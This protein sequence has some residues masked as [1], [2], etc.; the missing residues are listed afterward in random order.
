M[1]TEKE[2]DDTPN[3]VGELHHFVNPPLGEAWPSVEPS[4]AQDEVSPISSEQERHAEVIKRLDAINA[5]QQRSE[6]LL[7]QIVDLLSQEK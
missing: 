4:Q 7:Q 3:A 6:A 1:V 5:S 2:G